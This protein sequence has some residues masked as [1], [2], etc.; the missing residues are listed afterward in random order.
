M[1]PT[2][3]RLI[4]ENA[5][6]QWGDSRFACSCGAKVYQ[7]HLAIMHAFSG[8]ETVIE[9]FRGGRWVFDRE[10]LMAQAIRSLRKPG[11]SMPDFTRRIQA[12]LGELEKM[13]IARAASKEAEASL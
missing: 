2:R 11:E 6:P 12:R 7:S 8:H 9:T 3:H 4:D 1:T 5:L 13:A 10:D